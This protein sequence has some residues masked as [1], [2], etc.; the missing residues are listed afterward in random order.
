MYKSLKAN[1]ERDPLYEQFP[2]E[3]LIVREGKL[4]YSGCRE[5]IFSKKRL[6][7]ILKAGRPST[8]NRIVLLLITSLQAS[9]MS[10]YNKR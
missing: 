5:I 4:F 7:S 1:L 2:G 8:S 9:V 3:N 10:Q 6:F